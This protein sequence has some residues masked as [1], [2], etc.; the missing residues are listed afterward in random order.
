MLKVVLLLVKYHCNYYVSRIKKQQQQQ[1]WTVV[2]IE[3]VKLK[4]HQSSNP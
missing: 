2:G 1:N 3:R 4:T